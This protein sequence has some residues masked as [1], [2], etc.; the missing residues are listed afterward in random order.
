V[1]CSSSVVALVSCIRVAISTIASIGAAISRWLA[2]PFDGP[3]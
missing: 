2:Q 3:E 1:S